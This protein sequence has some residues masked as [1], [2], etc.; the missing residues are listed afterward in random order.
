WHRQPAPGGSVFPEA[1]RRPL[2]VTAATVPRERLCAI[3]AVADVAV[4]DASPLDLQAVWR[5]LFE[6]YGVRRL[7]SEGG[8]RF[9]HGCLKE[10]LVDEIFWTV[11]PRIAGSS[12]NLTMV[13]GPT[14]LHPMARLELVS[15]Y[16]HE[17][18]LFLRWRLVEP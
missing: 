1:P 14:L 17:N 2:V 10:G 8:P 6:A 13:S 7:L 12:H 5:L 16:C 9:N 11:A 15:A 4:L 3:E 18:E